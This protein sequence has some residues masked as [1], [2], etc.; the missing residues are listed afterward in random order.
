MHLQHFLSITAI[1]ILLCSDG[2]GAL[3]RAAFSKNLVTQITQSSSSSR[4]STT[5][6]SLNGFETLI[7]SA[8]STNTDAVGWFGILDV[9]R[10][11]EWL[12]SP[13]QSSITN[14]P[15]I[16]RIGVGLLLIDLLPL[17]LELLVF[18]SFL[19]TQTLE[20][21]QSKNAISSAEVDEFF[22]TVPFV[23]LQRIL[24]L[25]SEAQ[26][27]ASLQEDWWKDTKILAEAIA[28]LGPAT[29]LLAKAY[30]ESTLC[31][32][33]LGA[34][35]EEMF[36]QQ[37]A[38]PLSKVEVEAILTSVDSQAKLRGIKLRS[39]FSIEKGP[40]SF[41]PLGNTYMSKRGDM[42]IIVHPPLIKA[43]IMLDFFIIEKALS[44]WASPPI[45]SIA[46]Q[47]TRILSLLRETRENVIISMSAEENN[48]SVLDLKQQPRADI[49]QLV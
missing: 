25:A 32:R 24:E 34:D 26:K 4:R 49:R 27:Y 22:N 12:P 47:S 39:E 7:E 14:Q 28:K 46:D 18:K 23:V 41:S 21:M 40:A 48:I 11:S 37:L 19:K 42:A 36:A 43:R 29:Q 9:A 45:T 35:L 8:M 17:M 3:S 6:T 10:Y 13:L 1:L 33:E 2:A 16:L 15:V 31:S 38:P 44:L 5:R 20:S 30:S